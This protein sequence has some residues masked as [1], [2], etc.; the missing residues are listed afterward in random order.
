MVDLVTYG[1]MSAAIVYMLVAI[2]SI[3]SRRRDR[4]ITRPFRMPLFPLPPVIVVCFLLIAIGSQE[5]GNQIVVGTFV[6]VAL[7]YYFGYIRPRD[8][9]EERERNAK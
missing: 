7:V 3:N 1:G 2:G 4:N 9:R 6:L 8:L 5:T